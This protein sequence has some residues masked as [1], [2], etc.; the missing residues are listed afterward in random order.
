MVGF[1]GLVL[2]EAFKEVAVTEIKKRVPKYLDALEVVAK[3]SDHPVAKI[4]QP[5]DNIKVDMI[6]RNESLEGRIHPITGVPFERRTIIFDNEE[7][8]GVFPKFDKVFEAE[9]TPEYFGETDY[10]QF[11]ECNKQLNDFLEKNPDF[12]KSFSKD[13][14]EQ[15]KDGISDGTAPDGYV[16]HHDPGIGK[17]Q[18]VDFDTHVQTGHTGGK[19]LWGGGSS[20]R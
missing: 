6:T 15:I 4:F 1:A 9:L 7:I 8:S 11:K 14:L 20:N 18:L 10:S 12:K 13:Q 16:W 3:K 5:N 19:S 17:M 2:K